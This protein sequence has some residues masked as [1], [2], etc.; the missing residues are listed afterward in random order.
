MAGTTLET[1]HSEYLV[2][3]TE[4]CEECK[5]EQPEVWIPDDH[6]E[7]I[8]FTNKLTV[9]YLMKD[10][11]CGESDTVGMTAEDEARNMDLTE[12]DLTPSLM[13]SPGCEDDD[14]PSGPKIGDSPINVEDN[15]HTGHLHDE[16]P[17]RYE[18]GVRTE[19]VYA[20]CD[21]TAVKRLWPSMP[22][23]KMIHTAEHEKDNLR[24]EPAKAGC[25]DQGIF[26]PLRKVWEVYVGCGRVSEELKKR[27]DCQVEIF[28]YQTGRDFDRPQDRAKFLKRLRTE[29]PDEVLIAPACKLWSSLQELSASRSDKARRELMR[30]RQRDHDAHLT[31]T[32]VVYEAQRRAGRHATTEHSHK[33]RAW[34]TKAY[35]KMK[36]YDCYVGQCA[37][38]LTLPGELGK[39]HPR[40]SQQR[41]SSHQLPLESGPQRRNQQRLGLQRSHSTIACGEAV[42]DVHGM[43]P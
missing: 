42:L 2:R 4:H 13:P 7:H 34:K 20:L 25:I 15:E 11:P 39:W 17:N 40:I 35:N 18:E 14:A 10:E 22:M 37:Y 23:M 9:E 19:F 29:E 30:K 5:R 31:F 41:R 38:G 24:K 3:L 28:L 43:F 33:S 32:A 26:S 27:G 12:C 6:E 1:C 16:E 36:G 8:D 21:R